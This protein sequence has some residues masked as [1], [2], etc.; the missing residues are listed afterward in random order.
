MFFKYRKLLHQFCMPS[1]SRKKKFTLFCSLKVV[2]TV[3]KLWFFFFSF[4][5][6]VYAK[7]RDKVDWKIARLLLLTHDIK[8]VIKLS[9]LFTSYYFFFFF[10]YW[11]FHCV[12]SARIRSFSGPY[13]VRKWKNTD[14]TPNTDNFHAMS[15]KKN[16]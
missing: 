16:K 6:H 9:W 12:K 8:D 4:V 1:M 5:V 3:S 15:L 11:A 10:L 7:Y 14:K 2:D 13:S